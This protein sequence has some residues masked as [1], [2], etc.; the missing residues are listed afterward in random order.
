MTG[1]LR[2]VSRGACAAAALHQNSVCSNSSAEASLPACSVSSEL[3]DI[4][5]N[6]GV[7]PVSLFGFISRL[8]ELRKD[9]PLHRFHSWLLSS[10]RCAAP[11]IIKPAAPF[12]A[13]PVFSFPCH[14]P[15][16]PE[17][18]E[19]PTGTSLER[20]ARRSAWLLCEWLVCLFTTMLRCELGR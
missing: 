16:P 20:V 8:D 6:I 15:R 5:N 2:R 7:S 19:T 10:R 18:S 12:E 1:G 4:V 13:L 14:L 3:H 11:S 17:T 9:T